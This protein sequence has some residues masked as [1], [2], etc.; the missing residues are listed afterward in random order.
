M[1]IEEYKPTEQLRPYIKAYVVIDNSC[2][3]GFRGHNVEGVTNRIVPSTSVAIAFRLKGQISYIKDVG[4]KVLPAITFS[5]LRKSVRLIHYE[6]NSAAL[7]VLFKEQGV[8]SFFQ[9]PVHEL[10]EQSVALDCYIPASEVLCVEERLV[11]ATDNLSRIACIEQFLIS[12]LIYRNPD[13]IVSEAV[14]K[15][16]SV[17]GNIRI[18]ELSN[19]L[20]ISQDALEKRFRK[21]TGSTPKQF[22]FIVKMNTIIRQGKSSVS[23]LDAA[24]ESGYY[25]QPHFNK[26]FKMFTGQTPTDFMKSSTYW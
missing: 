13:T 16:N 1:R 18:K 20:H 17:K 24:Y 15:I 11:G 5:G 6:R 10:F 7:I 2:A 8:A 19:H 25:D 9:Q 22:S 4:K 21:V 12:R 3:E 14:A 23:F 26:D